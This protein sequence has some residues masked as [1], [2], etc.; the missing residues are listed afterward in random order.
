MN[1]YNESTQYIISHYEID[2][3]DEEAAI[4]EE[5]MKMNNG[6]DK[7]IIIEN[8]RNWFKLKAPEEKLAKKVYQDM[9]VD[10][11][12]EAVYKE[13]KLDVFGR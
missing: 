9:L 4:I 1:K 6:S 13:Y 7:G 8:L 11:D 5:I 2:C 12:W 3:P 10:V